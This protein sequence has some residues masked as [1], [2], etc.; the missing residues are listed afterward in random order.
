[1]K[2]SRYKRDFTHSYALGAT[3]VY[4]LLAVHPELIQRVFLRPDITP[5]AD[6]ADLLAKLKAH[7]IETIETT[8]AFNVLDAKDN[9]LLIAEFTKP[10]TKLS[11]GPHLVLVNP[12]DS[13]NLGT[14]MRSATAFGFTNLAIISPAVDP[15]QPKVVRASMGAAFHLNI[16]EFPSFEQYRASVN[17]DRKY[18]AFMLNPNAIQLPDLKLSDDNFSL[19]FGNEAAGLPPEF[20]E[21]AT[22]VFIPQ[23]SAVDSLNLS[24]A[25]SLALYQFRQK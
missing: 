5:G 9:C 18:Y 13:G 21:I 12:S 23:S 10:A 20:A 6:L 3:L 14:I 19:V 15:Y 16:Q 8:K 24:V 11:A 1:M 22:P 7:H 25:T 17:Q 4:E 2:L